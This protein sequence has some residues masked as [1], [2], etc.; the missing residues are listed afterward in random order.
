MPSNPAAMLQFCVMRFR[1]RFFIAA[2]FLTA[3]LAS[4][5]V[6]FVFAEDSGDSAAL[7]DPDE[8]LADDVVVELPEADSD[9]A[10]ATPYYGN[11]PL[12][13]VLPYGA[14]APDDETAA[15]IAYGVAAGIVDNIYP[16]AAV[17]TIP[18]DRLLD[19]P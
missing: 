14:D 10:V 2:I 5:Q 19:K 7:P 4:M 13:L 8:M 6:A 16:L 11:M 9:A 17:R 12:I 3:L 1:I 15:A 18:L